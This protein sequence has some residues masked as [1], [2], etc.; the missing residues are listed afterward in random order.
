MK[1]LGKKADVIG[2]LRSSLI[3]RKYRVLF[4]AFPLTDRYGW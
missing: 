3:N 4:R 1:V 2:Y